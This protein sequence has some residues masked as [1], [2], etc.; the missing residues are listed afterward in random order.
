MILRKKAIQN[1]QLTDPNHENG[2]VG[3]VLWR[4]G[5]AAVFRLI[6]NFHVTF[7]KLK[8]DLVFNHILLRCILAYKYEFAQLLI[9]SCS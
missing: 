3:S 7:T 2:S 6:G 1:V 9:Y 4:Y 8:P 5:I